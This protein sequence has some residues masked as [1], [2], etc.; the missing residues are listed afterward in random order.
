MSALDYAKPV[1]IVPDGEYET[2]AAGAT[3]QVLGATGA[4]GDTLKR[5]ICVVTTVTTAQVQI[6]DGNGSAITVLPNVVAAVGT[7]V[8]ECDMVAINP[9]TPGWKVTT[10]AAVSVVA[11]GNFT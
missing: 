7:Y 2:V 9:T 4:V 5:L 3:D 1:K 6:K 11:V 8:I 10:A